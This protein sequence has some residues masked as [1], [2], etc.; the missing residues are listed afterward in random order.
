LP[1]VFGSAERA[2]R[3]SWNDDPGERSTDADGLVLPYAFNLALDPETANEIERIYARLAALQVPDR[4][5]ITQYGPCV[6]L[7]VVADGVSA[8][9]VTKVLAWKLPALGALPVT[10]TEPCIIPGAP[11]ALSLRASPTDGLLALH[12]AIYTELPEAEVHLHYR[13]AYWQ[14]HLK[15]ANVPGDQAVAAGLIAALAAEW[16]PLSGRL[17]RL[18]VMH[19]PPVQPIWQAPLRDG[20]RDV[21]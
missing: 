6:T 14:P 7:L 9:I 15:L 20:L 21:E 8:E 12:D 10:F 2:G 13:P 11:P 3:H 18:E 4:D 16:R 1:A 19:Y 5:L 17:D